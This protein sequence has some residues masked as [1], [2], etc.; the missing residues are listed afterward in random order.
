MADKKAKQKP[1]GKAKGKGGKQAQGLSVAS[2]PRAVAQV[3][4]AKGWGGLAGFVLAF[5]LS[6]NA[7]VP[8][9]VAG[10]RAIVAGVVGYMLAWACSV[11]IW[12]QLML[13]EL[14]HAAELA[15][16]RRADA[17]AATPTINPTNQT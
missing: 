5:Y 1:K 8:I 16:Q 3:R 17:A 9:V 6:L 7:S 13:A 10:E 12:R 14:R 15:Q 4:R 2:H 11:T